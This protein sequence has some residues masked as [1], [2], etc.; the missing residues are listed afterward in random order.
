M[1]FNLFKMD[2][3]R[4]EKIPRPWF[5]TLQEYGPEGARA[6]TQ[7]LYFFENARNAGHRVA[8]D[9]RVRVGHFDINTDIVW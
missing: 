6:M 7:D 8:C 5:K 1:G 3:F 2:L 4:D 9:T